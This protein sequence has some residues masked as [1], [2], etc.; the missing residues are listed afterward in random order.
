MGLGMKTR[1][2]QMSCETGSGSVALR[3]FSPI[4]WVPLPPYRD[5]VSWKRHG[6]ITSSAALCAARLL[7]PP[8]L[9][10]KRYQ[11]FASSEH[12]FCPF[13]FML[14]GSWEAETRRLYQTLVCFPL[15]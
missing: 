7:S 8:V 6:P 15:W 5:Q 14:L 13:A 4:S 11:R 2:V 12:W 10:I 9:R 1:C 3:P